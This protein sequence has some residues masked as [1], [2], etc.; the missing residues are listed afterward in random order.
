MNDF[1][2]PEGKQ[3]VQECFFIPFKISGQYKMVL[4]QWGKPD[5]VL[6]IVIHIVEVLMIC[7][8]FRSNYHFPY[9]LVRPKGLI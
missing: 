9:S 7:I 5:K 4:S 3:I 8:Q 6:K 2:K 1:P